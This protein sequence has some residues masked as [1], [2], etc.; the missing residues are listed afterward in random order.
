MD[1]GAECKAGARVM[2]FFD[3]F[4]IA[5][6]TNA[7][8][9]EKE[10]TRAEKSAKGFQERINATESS[11]GKLAQNLLSVAATGLAT[12]ASF[13]ALK[14][15]V[16]NAAAFNAEIYRNSQLAQINAKELSAWEAAFS[17]VT[18]KRGEF[19]SWFVN[20][21]KELQKIG[22]DASQ[23][24][25]NLRALADEIAAMPEQEARQFFQMISEQTGLPDS[26]YLTLRKGGA[27]LDALIGRQR[28]MVAV[29]DESARVAQDFESAWSD[30]TNS[31]RHAFT[32][33]GD[34]VLPFLTKFLNL[35]NG[36]TYIK[37]PDWFLNL[38]P[39]SLKAEGLKGVLPAIS[40]ESANDTGIDK[41]Y[42]SGKQPLGIR[43]N[44]PGN[45]VYKGQL[46]AT[47]GEGGFAKFATLEEGLKA[48]QRQLEIYGSRGWNTLEKIANKW[49]PPNENDTDKYI[50]KLSRQTG[51]APN[52]ALNLADPNVRRMISNAINANE[53]GPAYGHML[54]VAKDSISSADTSRLNTQSTSAASNQNSVH[55]GAVNVYTQATDADGVA[56]AVNEKLSEHFRVTMGNYDDGVAR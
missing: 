2:A 38:L 39:S 3:Q 36:I 15:G 26:F 27:E 23:V 1:C 11:V 41:P 51:Y 50:E 21:S 42:A 8:D 6:R 25:P 30:T 20:Y 29:S 49:A 12:Y 33:L 31:I 44:N 16:T 56:R 18:G 37:L 19:T 40:P 17:R 47:M 48:Q 9:A 7:K 45:L 35:L 10:M 22:L 54:Q 53:N 52:Q 5:F 13:E 34:I 14:S 32:A 24:L 4:F 28:E 43:N 55:V 46:G